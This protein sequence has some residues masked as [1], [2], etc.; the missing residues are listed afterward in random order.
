MS[1]RCMRYW[2]W[3][4]NCVSEYSAYMVAYHRR[5]TL[6]ELTAIKD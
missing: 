2:S 3:V 1:K 4:Y 5:Y 6:E